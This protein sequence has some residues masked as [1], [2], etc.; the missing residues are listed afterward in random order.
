MLD[1]IWSEAE[2]VYYVLDLLSWKDQRL[3]DCTADFR[4]Y[5]LASKLEAVRPACL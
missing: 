3:V 5:W 2:Q 1:C 4:R